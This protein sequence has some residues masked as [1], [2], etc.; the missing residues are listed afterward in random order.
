VLLLL[1]LQA[2]RGLPTPFAEY[3]DLPSDVA[4]HLRVDKDMA[5]AHLDAEVVGRQF[6]RG[7]GDRHYV[8]VKSYPAFEGYS[9]QVR[10]FGLMA[11]QVC[12]RAGALV[13]LFRGGL[14]GGELVVHACNRVCILLLCFRSKAC[15]N[16][17]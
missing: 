2:A 8:R 7:S 1:L 16:I 13:R 12:G 15:C 11:E 4:A 14:L 9:L 3:P 17:L 5:T 6:H 10:M